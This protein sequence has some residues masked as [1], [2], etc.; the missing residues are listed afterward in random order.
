M[1][2]KKKEIKKIEYTKPEILDLGPVTSAMGVA[3]CT[4]LGQS[5]T[6]NCQAGDSPGQTCLAG[7][8]IS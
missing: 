7:T 5:A 1:E 2:D 4:P 3:D 6:I 8:G